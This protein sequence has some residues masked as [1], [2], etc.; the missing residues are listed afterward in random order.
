MDENNYNNSNKIKKDSWQFIE[1]TSWLDT[2]EST[3]PI[4]KSEFRGFFNLATMGFIF[5]FITTQVKNILNEGNMYI[6]FIYIF[7]NIIGTPAGWSSLHHMFN[8]FNFLFIIF[9]NIYTFFNRH[10]LFPAWCCLCL[11]SF[12][13]VILQKLKVKGSF[14]YFFFL[15]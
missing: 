7:N 8:R 11:S 2:L 10:D 4:E 13:A 6:C 15:L 12:S 3:S 5:F 9:F 1:R 14:I